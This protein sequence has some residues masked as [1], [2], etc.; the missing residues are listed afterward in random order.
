MGK[1]DM[2]QDDKLI[3]LKLIEFL[4]KVYPTADF[5]TV[6]KSKKGNYILSSVWDGSYEDNSTDQMMRSE[7][8]EQICKLI[9]L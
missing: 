5:H 1:T 6:Y 4:K 3:E 7:V 8:V 9:K 2:A